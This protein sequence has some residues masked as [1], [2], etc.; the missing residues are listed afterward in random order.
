MKTQNPVIHDSF[1][2]CYKIYPRISFASILD[3]RGSGC[4]EGKGV[5][6]FLV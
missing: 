3:P 4:C 6:I 2:D 5:L 1:D